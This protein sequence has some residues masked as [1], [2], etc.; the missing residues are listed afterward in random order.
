MERGK[1]CAYFSCRAILDI[2]LSVS[3]LSND[4]PKTHHCVP[5]YLVPSLQY[6]IQDNPPTTL[7]IDSPAGD[8]MV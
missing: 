5:P 2:A 8:H 4:T 7:H 1:Q 6:T 3:V